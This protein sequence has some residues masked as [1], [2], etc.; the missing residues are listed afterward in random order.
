MNTAPLLVEDTAAGIEH[1]REEIIRLCAGPEGGH[2]G[3]S[4]SALEMVAAVHLHSAPQ[5]PAFVLS[6]GHSALA[7]YAVLYG[8]GRLSLQEL[9]SFCLPGS[10][11]GTHTNSAVDG[12]AVST[13]SLGH[14][15]AVAAGW[16]LG[17]RDV[18]RQ[19]YVVLGDGETQE[20]SVAE[21]ARV[22]A[23]QQL[24]NLTV[25]VDLNGAQQTGLVGA[26]NPLPDTEG[27]WRAMGWHVV[28]VE[29]GNEVSRV[30]DAV[31][32]S[33]RES[34]PTVLLC[35]TTKGYGAGA[36]AGDP[37]SHFVTLS[38]ERLDEVL[39]GRQGPVS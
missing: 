14:G 18:G 10:A 16:A 7:L 1:L 23:N 6:K 21:A 5:E 34:G 11:L 29:Q 8:M 25:L 35:H 15:L 12:V 38:A 2:L 33:G 36:L 4:L 22:A 27:W 9:R 28:A 37:A 39:V 19:V 31:R 20:G 32:G 3:G 24:N 26:I 30:R 17:V 13:G